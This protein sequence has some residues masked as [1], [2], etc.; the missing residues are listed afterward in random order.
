MNEI[1]KKFRDVGII[2]VVV[3]EHEEQAEKLADVLCDNGLP[4]AEVT[5]RTEAAAK[6][7]AAMV[8]HRPEMLVGA[9]TVLTTEEVDSAVDAGAKFIV[10]PGLNPTV[11]KYCQS[12]NIP[13]APGTQTP[14]EMEQ[15]IS[16]GLDFVKFFPA[17]Q[18]G[19]LNMIRAVVAPY[20]R[21]SFM[22]TG[23]INPDNVRQYLADDKI[24]ACG[25]S[26][27]VKQS[28]LDE[29]NWKVVAKLVKEAAAI[30]REVRGESKLVKHL[31]A[32]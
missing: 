26:W 21:L 4:C 13:V 17:E 10:S 23:G 25:G 15:A 12:R 19:G 2:P 31:L 24:V 7:I 1:F 5:F 16:L 30:V 22:P 6:V 20:S 28:L 9:G 27:M 32:S 29:G 3:M 14:S 8:K 18:S 11:V